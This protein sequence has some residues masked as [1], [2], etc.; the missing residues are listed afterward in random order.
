MA[1]RPAGSPA[2][3]RDAVVQRQQ[4]ADGI[5]ADEQEARQRHAD[6]RARRRQPAAATGANR[7]QHRQRQHEAQQQEAKGGGMRQ[8]HLRR[9]RRRSTAARTS[10][11]EPW[12]AHAFRLKDM[13]FYLSMSEQI[14]ARAILSRES[15]ETDARTAG[16]VQASRQAVGG[17]GRSVIGRSAARTGSPERIGT[18]GKRLSGG[19]RPTAGT[20]PRRRRRPRRRSAGPRAAAPLRQEETTAP[21]VMACAGARPAARTAL[22][23][24]AMD[25]KSDMSWG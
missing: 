18:S 23:V 9:S 1:A 15:G 22:A 14:R 11:V 25:R 13:S 20:G 17:P 21:R 8:P 6:A 12:A 4:I 2:P 16:R 3:W 5:A 10:E 24:T 19:R 7:Q